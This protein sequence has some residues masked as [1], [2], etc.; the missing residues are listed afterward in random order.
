VV[1]PFTV[2]R[3]VGLGMRAADFLNDNDAY[4]FFEKTKDLLI[5]GPTHTNVMDV[6]LVLVR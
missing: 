4:P 6:R 1:D 5:T 3:G 2:K